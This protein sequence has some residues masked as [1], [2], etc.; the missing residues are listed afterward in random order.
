M[1]KIYVGVLLV[2]IAST[3][4][5]SSGTQSLTDIAEDQVIAR[6][7]LLSPAEKSLL[8]DKLERFRR[9]TL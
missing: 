8:K 1:N 9:L 5:L 4:V 6:I 2:L 7:G 3:Y